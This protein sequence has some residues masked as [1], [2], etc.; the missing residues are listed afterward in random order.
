MVFKAI[1]LSCLVIFSFNSLAPLLQAGRARVIAVT[2]G[3]RRGDPLVPTIAESGFPGFD[4]TSWSG[5]F[6]RAGTPA[7]IIRKLADAFNHATGNPAVRERLAAIG[8]E[9]TQADPNAFASRLV[10]E[11]EVIRIII[12]DTGITFQ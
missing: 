10:A 12:R 5:V 4:L 3:I 6:V 1:T 9:P 11:R 2:S 7:P 8:S